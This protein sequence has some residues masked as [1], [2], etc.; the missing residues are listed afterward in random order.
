MEGGGGTSDIL[1]HLHGQL[2]P[3]S[4]AL[5]AARGVVVKRPL[6]GR[7]ASP[8][9]PGTEATTGAGYGSTAKRI[10]AQLRG[11][12]SQVS[13]TLLDPATQLRMSNFKDALDT[14][15]RAYVPSCHG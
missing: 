9:E 8:V 1:T 11:P 15:N 4:D 3:D 12:G 13:S 7:G 6:Y 10:D 2:G 5:N 14:L